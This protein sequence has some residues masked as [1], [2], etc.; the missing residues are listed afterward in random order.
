MELLMVEDEDEAEVDKVRQET[1]IVVFVTDCVA[2][3]VDW[4]NLVMW[5]NHQ[6]AKEKD[7]GLRTNDGDPSIGPQGFQ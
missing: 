5:K 7:D 1:S 4:V 2:W 6:I 3:V